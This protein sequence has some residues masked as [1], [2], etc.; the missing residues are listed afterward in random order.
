MTLKEA[1]SQLEALGSERQRVQ[2][3]KH[4]GTEKFPFAVGAGENQFGV[5]NGDIRN[6]AKAIKVNEELSEELWATGNYDAMLLS[7]L[8]TNPKKLSADDVDRKVRQIDASVVADWF[9]T[10]I[11][12]LHPQKE[13]LR[14]KWMADSS[15]EAASRAGWSLTVERVVKNPEGIDPKALLD[16]IDNEISTAPPMIQWMQNYCLSEIGINFPELRDRAIAIGEKYGI[17]QDYKASKGCTSPYAPI[18][19]E[20]MVNR[21]S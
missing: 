13:E 1:M 9:N 18:W 19:I 5:K 14:Q 4:G 16:R 10:N 6:L 11:T 3:S 2:N 12:K 15:N 21:Q 8:I 17:Y 20:A 7:T